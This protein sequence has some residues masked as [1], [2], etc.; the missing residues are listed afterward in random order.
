[1][2]NSIENVWKFKFGPYACH[3]YYSLYSKLGS[4]YDACKESKTDLAS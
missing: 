1:M 4:S 2:Q 3:L